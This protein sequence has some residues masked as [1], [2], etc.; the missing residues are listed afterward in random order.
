[1]GEGADC[2]GAN[3][4]SFLRL[5]EGQGLP[6]RCYALPHVILGLLTQEIAME[7]TA[8]DQVLGQLRA[9]AALAGGGGAKATENPAG[10]TADFASV[11][12]ASLDQANGMQ[13]QAAKVA[14]DFEVG[15]TDASLPDVMV[16]IQKANVSFQQVVQVRNRLVSAYHEIMNMQV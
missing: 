7:T 10:K 14:R 3:K 16:S 8:L 5:I 9:A 11:L 12:K 1:M 2:K 15:A 4:G 13:Q 6:V